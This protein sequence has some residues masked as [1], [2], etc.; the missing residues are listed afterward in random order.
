M[1]ARPG[2]HRAEEWRDDDIV[3]ALAAAGAL[4]IPAEEAA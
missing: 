1:L 3:Q 4:S 2:R